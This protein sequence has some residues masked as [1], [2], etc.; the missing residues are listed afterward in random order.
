MY[1]F[2]NSQYFLLLFFYFIFFPT[3]AKCVLGVLSPNTQGCFKTPLESSL[4]L[5]STTNNLDT[6]SFAA[7][8]ILS[9]Y[10][11]GNLNYAFKIFSNKASLSSS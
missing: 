7:F 11:E 8:D 4:F 5:G 1:H 2:H 6:K 10:G 9:Q 3:L